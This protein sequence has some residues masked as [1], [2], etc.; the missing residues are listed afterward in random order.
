ML[1]VR[2]PLK[3]IV[4]KFLVRLWIIGVDERVSFLDRGRQA[5]EIEEH[6]PGQRIAIGLGRRMK[7][8]V[9]ASPAARNDRSHCAASVAMLRCGGRHGPR[10]VSRTTNAWR[11]WAPCSIHRRNTAISSAESG[12]PN[13]AGGIRCD[14]SECVIRRIN[15]LASGLPGTIAVA[16]DSN[17]D[18][19]ILA[20]SSRR[21][22]W[23]VPRPGRGRQSTYWTE[24]VECR[25]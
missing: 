4:D 24:S 18:V 16:P 3:Q 1:A 2:R 12:L 13:S 21:P 11:K 14:S 15:S 5:G 20:S 6:A 22:A 17:S 7:T 23:R 8:H 25:D 19:A 10:P 9:L